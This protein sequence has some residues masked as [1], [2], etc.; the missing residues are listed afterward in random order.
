MHETDLVVIRASNGG[1]VTWAGMRSKSPS[2]LFG[3][4][5][6]NGKE[7]PA[8]AA[9]SNPWWI[10][11]I[12]FNSVGLPSYRM[13]YYPVNGSSRLQTS[14]RPAELHS[15]SNFPPVTRYLL[16]DRPVPWAFVGRHANCAES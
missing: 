6:F 12:F 7:P 2:H 3:W 15:T 13:Y 8:A 4:L 11:A 9:L 14:T 1:R 5:S 10:A 16:N